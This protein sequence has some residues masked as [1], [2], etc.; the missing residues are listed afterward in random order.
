MSGDDYLGRSG[1]LRDVVPAMINSYGGGGSSS[2]LLAV[3]TAIHYCY[4]GNPHSKRVGGKSLSM[5]LQV[6]KTS[7]VDISPDVN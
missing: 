3:A 5:L 1:P 2:R 7:A 4:I 6:I